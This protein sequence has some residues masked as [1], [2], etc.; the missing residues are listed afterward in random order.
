MKNLKISRLSSLVIGIIMNC[1]IFNTQADILVIDGKSNKLECYI[2]ISGLLGNKTVVNGKNK[3]L[4][5]Y[6]ENGTV[7]V[8]RFNSFNQLLNGL[9]L[10]AQNSDF[11]F[12]LEENYVVFLNVKTTEE[13]R[14]EYAFTIFI[15]NNSASDLIYDKYCM[16]LN[17]ATIYNILQKYEISRRKA[18]EFL[19]QTNSWNAFK[20]YPKK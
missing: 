15:G 14:V 16:G 2:G 19:D 12:K 1:G 6:I 9:G 5:K 7:A 8:A 20:I 13:I 10:P 11:D 3:K 17:N 18:R 4:E